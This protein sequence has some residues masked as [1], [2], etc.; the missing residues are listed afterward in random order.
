VY[1]KFQTL[2][3]DM[4]RVLVAKLVPDLK[5]QMEPKLRALDEAFAKRLGVAGAT[6]PAQPAKAPAKK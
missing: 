6:A 1:V 2:G 5:P 4:Q 3:G